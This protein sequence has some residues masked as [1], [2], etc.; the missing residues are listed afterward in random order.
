MTM[1]L[2]PD[3][4]HGARRAAARFGA[5]AAMVIASAAILIVIAGR[6]DF[7]GGGFH[8][9]FAMLLGAVGT[10]AVGVGLMALVFYSSRSGA[11]ERVKSDARDVNQP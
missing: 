8:V 1:S 6:F 10:I 5:V 2:P 4:D 9:N 11:D 7:L 3:R